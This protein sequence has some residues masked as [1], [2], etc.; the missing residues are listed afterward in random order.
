MPNGILIIDKPA[1]WTSMDVCAKVRGILREKRVGH[2]GTLDPMATGVLPVFVGRATRGVEFAEKGWKEYAAGLRLGVSTDTQDVTGTVLETRPVTAGREDVEAALAAFRGDIQ[3]VPPMYSAV[4]IQ[5]KK[6]YELARRGKEVERKPRPVTIRELELLEAESGTD[7]RLRCLCS[8]GT[9]IR[10]LCH[11]IGQRL[12][13]GGTL[14]SLRRTMAAGFTLA[15]AVTLEEVQDRGEALL[16]PLDGLFA[17]YPALTVRSPGQEKR[18][19]CGNPVTLPGTADG[20]YRVYGQ[21]GDFLCLS[22]ARDG[23]L[24]SVKNFF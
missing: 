18:V 20:T 19:R 22:Q 21:T 7:Y 2:G 5:G 6:L 12:G 10:T 8:K 24:S 15:E 17:Q 11:D 23:V 4:K 16:Q 1:G 3:Q 14:Y 13:C 9:Y